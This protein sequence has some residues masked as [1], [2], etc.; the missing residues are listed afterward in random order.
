MRPSIRP[1]AA[2]D[3]HQV[4]QRLGGMFVGAVAGV[5]DRALHVLGQQVRRAGRG[6]RTTRTSAPMASMLRAVS[7]NDSPLERLEPPGGEVLGVGREP[8][9]RQAEAGAGAGRV[10]EEQVED[11]T[12]LKRGNLL[13][14]AGRDLGER[15]GGIQDRDDL[16]ASR[17][18]PDP[19]RCLRV[20]ASGARTEAG[21][22]DAAVT[23][24][25]SS[26]SLRALRPGSIRDDLLDRD[27]RGEAGPA[28]A[29][30][31]RSSTSRPTTSGWIGIS[32]W[33]RSTSTASRTDAGR[34]RSQTA[35]RAGADRPAGEQDI[36][37]QHHLGA[38]DVEGDLGPAQHG[39][40]L[41][42]AQVVAVEG[43]V[44]GADRDLHAE[45]LA[46]LRGEPIGEGHAPGADADQ[47]G[48]ARRGRRVRRAPRPSPRSG[49]STAVPSQIRRSPVHSSGPPDGPQRRD[50]H[51]WNCSRLSWGVSSSADGGRAAIRRFDRRHPVD[52]SNP[53]PHDSACPPRRHRIR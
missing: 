30:P 21:G 32:R 38:I 52:P 33:P 39:P 19:S 10:L 47:V 5:D 45:Q 9:G 35:L 46:Q 12:A 22:C 11:D 53:D 28:H 27:R 34:P 23:G 4:E 6:W 2:A 49:R 42:L 7:M 43:D 8:L 13:A 26:P 15:L 41:G 14:A 48:G 1:L 44:H 16:V 36:V 18:P 3:G 40:V 17:D 51:V 50:R 25:R 31:A 20:Q 24:R 37:D 29:R